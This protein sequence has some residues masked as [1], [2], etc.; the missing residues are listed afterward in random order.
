MERREWLGEQTEQK[1]K[2]GDK[3]NS[4]GGRLQTRRE[5]DHGSG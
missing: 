3:F 1:A 2:E 5:R 4:N